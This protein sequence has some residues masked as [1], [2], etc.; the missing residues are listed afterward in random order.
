MVKTV[1]TLIF[2]EMNMVNRM[3][4]YQLH[5]SSKV[6]EIFSCPLFQSKMSLQMLLKYGINIRE[7]GTSDFF[8]MVYTYEFGH[9]DYEHHDFYIL[10]IAFVTKIRFLLN[11][12]IRGGFHS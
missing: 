10:F 5:S 4:F 7:A 3:W 8:G 9:A 12:T 11:F 6:L 1:E 2:E